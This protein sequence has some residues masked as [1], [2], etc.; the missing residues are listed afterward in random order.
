MARIVD[1]IVEE[2]L[3]EVERA[4]RKFPLWPVDPLH[5]VAVVA[6]ESGELVKATLESVYE[7]SK[8]RL[9]DAR[10]E[11]I[12]VAAMAIRFVVGCESYELREAEQVLQVKGVRP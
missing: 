7:P 11:A 6:E 4:C 8:A 1:G 9:Q 12:Q 3:Q 2:V 5:A 10:A